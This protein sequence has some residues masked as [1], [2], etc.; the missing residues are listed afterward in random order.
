M[1]LDRQW[2][3]L[4]EFC[5][6][7]SPCI[8]VPN[9]DYLT[10]AISPGLSSSS[11]YLGV[12]HAD[13]VEHYDHANRLGRYWNRFVCV[14]GYLVGNLKEIKL[15]FSSEKVR[16]IPNGVPVP[17][18]AAIQFSGPTEPLRIV[19]CA[20]LTQHQKRV[21]DLVKITAELERRSISYRLTVIG[22]GSEERALSE[23]WQVQ[24]KRGSVVMTGRLS[25]Q[26]AL[27]ELEKSEVFLLVS[28]FE[29]MPISLLEAM[30]RGLVPVVSDI[31]AGIPELVLPGQTGFTARVG[32]I[33]QFAG[34][35]AA[36]CE[37]R[38][39]LRR[40]SEAARSH[41]KNHGFTDEFM[42]TSY[43]D[44][45]EEIW[46]EILQ[47]TYRRPRPI[48]WKVPGGEVSPPGF[49]LKLVGT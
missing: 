21:L 34:H 14:T 45:I 5:E 19:Y 47:G 9:Y 4:K 8:L 48:M 17:R 12:I 13:D 6:Q 25:H 32:N 37:D 15:G 22:E 1:P 49:A 26:D 10:S 20:R 36:L 38:A 27:A 44:V 24:I 35:L 46:F 41:I 3:V 7:Q 11:G 2:Q 42:V 40:L 33:K 18:G 29:G 43:L 23:A 31:P 16:V 39:L 30:A 28:D